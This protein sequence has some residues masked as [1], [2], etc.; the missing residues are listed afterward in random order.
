M[1]TDL[2]SDAHREV[3]N[4]LRQARLDAGLTQVEL[5]RRLKKSQS[6]VSHIE[7]SLRRVDIP[8]LVA[9]ARALGLRPVDLFSRIEERLPTTLEID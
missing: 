6:F 9:L 2:R 5:A 7:S 3:V 8:E 4:A 1:P